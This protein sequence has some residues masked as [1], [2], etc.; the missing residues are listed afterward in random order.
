ME[1][2]FIIKLGSSTILEGTSIFEEIKHVVDDGYKVLLVTG[3]ADAIKQQYNSIQR[4]MPFLTLPNGDEVRYC[5]PTEM[6]IIKDSYKDII[7]PKVKEA[8]SK[9]NLSVFTQLGGDNEVIIGRKAKPLKAIRNNKSIIVRD[10]LFGTYEKSNSD[11]LK[12]L[13]NCYDVVCVSPP[14]YD[15][16]LD[17]YINIDADMLAAHLATDLKAKHIRFV[18]STPGILRDIEDSSSTIKDIYLGEELNSVKGK[19]KQ[20]VRAA[21][22]SVKNGICDV[23]IVGPHT[24]NGKGKT[25]F[26][27][28]PDDLGDLEFLNKCIRIPSTSYNEREFAQFVLNNIEKENISG[29]ID[30]V[31]NLIFQKGNGPNRLMLLGHMDTVPYNWKVKNTEEGI[32]GRGVVDAKSSLVNFLHMLEEVDVP[33]DGTLM[34]IGAVEEEVSSSKGAHYIRDNYNAD[35]VIIGEPSGEENLTLGYYGLYKLKIT[36]AKPQEHS[37]GKDAISELDLLY[38]IVD[39]IRNKVDKIDSKNLSSLIRVNSSHKEGINY[40]TG[41]L[42]FRISPEAGKNYSENLNF[43]FGEFVNVEVL[44]TT[45]GFSNPRNC[46]LVKSFIYGFSAHGK[47]INYLKKRGTSDMNTLA[48]SWNEVPM[49]AYGP[50]D[51]SLD[52]TSE[53][54]VKNTEIRNARQILKDSIDKWFLLQGGV[55]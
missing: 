31:G 18:T 40:A 37:A 46:K 16:N 14:I 42:N 45:P 50:G 22:W 30:E 53:E 52:H 12:N 44:R 26:W 15:T 20:K 6:P 49:V 47:K 51:S 13:L 17:S 7:F 38:S 27:D 28:M 11:L 4:E 24:L 10:S 3:G 54:F 48:V 35:A 19:M 2:I 39:K 34:V 5:S 43:D 23:C 29:K 25:W 36:I 33:K 55:K 1:N 8:L 9:Y 41:I 32:H 21:N